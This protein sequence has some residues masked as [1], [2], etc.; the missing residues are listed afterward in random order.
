MKYI[1]KATLSTQHDVNVGQKDKDNNPLPVKLESVVT[2]NMVT[3]LNTSGS[4][5]L[6]ADAIKTSMR[7]QFEIPNA[8]SESLIRSGVEATGSLD[9]EYNLFYSA[10]VPYVAPVSG[11]EEETTTTTTAAPTTSTTTTSTT[12]APT[13][14][15]TT[16]TT[17]VIASGSI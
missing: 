6:T 13:T 9:N 8:I 10:T 17:T 4:V 7:T 2:Y 16:S 11:S 12:P 14:S 15:T 5:K 3:G 1:I